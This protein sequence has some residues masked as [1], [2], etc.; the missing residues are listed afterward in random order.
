MQTLGQKEEAG[1]V[2]LRVATRIS[3]NCQ[4]AIM[5]DVS[6]PY[7]GTLVHIFN[8]VHDGLPR[9]RRGIGWV[10]PSQEAKVF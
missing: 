4:L 6:K 7:Y 5:H 2:Y 1:L 3:C 9:R 8:E 10:S